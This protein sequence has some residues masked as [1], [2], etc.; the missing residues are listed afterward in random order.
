MKMVNLI[1][2]NDGIVLIKNKNGFVV[3]ILLI[4]LWFIFEF[5]VMFSEKFYVGWLM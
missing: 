4:K 3:W 2:N 1:R 5:G